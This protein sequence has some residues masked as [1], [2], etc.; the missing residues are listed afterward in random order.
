M[1]TPASMAAALNRSRPATEST[2][3]VRATRPRK[4]GSPP[5]LVRVDDLVGDQNVFETFAAISASPTVA[6]VSPVHEPAAS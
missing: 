3:T 4:R 2:A 5:A 6:Q 1:V